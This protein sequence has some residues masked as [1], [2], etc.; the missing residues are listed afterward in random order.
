MQCDLGGLC[1]P[2]HP[3][4]YPRSKWGWYVV[5]EEWVGGLITHHLTAVSVMLTWLCTLAHCT[6]YSP[7]LQPFAPLAALQSPHSSAAAP[8]SVRNRC[9]ESLSQHRFEHET[10]LICVCILFVLFRNFSLSAAQDVFIGAPTVAS[11]SFELFCEL[12]VFFIL[13]CLSLPSLSIFQ[14]YY[15]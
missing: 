14:L 13:L 9:C 11:L 15:C 5:A 12:G 2:L 7:I 10:V 8:G 1:M 3:L 6:L 4:A